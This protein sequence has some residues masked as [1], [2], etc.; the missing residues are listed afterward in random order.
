MF[1]C[2]YDVFIGQQIFLD[3]GSNGL[4]I[5]SI[6]RELNGISEN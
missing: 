2:H 3:W 6:F 4:E 5:L 1:D